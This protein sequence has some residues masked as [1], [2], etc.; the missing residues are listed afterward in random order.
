[1][2]FAPVIVTS[3]E[4]HDRRTCTAT[5]F[6]RARADSGM[7]GL[8]PPAPPVSSMP[9][10]DMVSVE[11]TSSEEEQRRREPLRPSPAPTPVVTP[12]SSAP[13]LEQLKSK[14]FFFVSL[15]GGLHLVKR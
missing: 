15:F 8:Q 1:M 3:H 7:G 11:G 9:S 14:E 5:R 6:L 12:L 2:P 10:V 13:L 4:A